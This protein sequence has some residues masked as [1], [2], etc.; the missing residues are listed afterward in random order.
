MEM[1]SLW[2]DAIHI[3]MEDGR[4]KGKEEGIKT[5]R[6]EGQQMLILHLLQNVLGQLTPEI[7]KRIQQCD[8][9]MLQVIGMHIH[10]IH[11]EQDVFKL[12]ITC[13]KNNKERV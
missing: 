4:K 7:K 1:Y 13:Y 10:Q 5:G 12:L 3:G 9:H 6:R 2:K 8:E 11:N